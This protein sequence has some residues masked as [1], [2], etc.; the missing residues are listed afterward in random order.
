MLRFA[1]LLS[2]CCAAFALR[3]QVQTMTFSSGA[4]HP[5]FTFTNWNTDNYTIWNAD[6]SQDAIIAY[7]SGTFTLISFEVG[8]FNG[9]NTIQLTS[10]NGDTLEYN[11]SIDSVYTLNW[12]GITEIRHRRVFGAGASEDIDNV[13]VD[14]STPACNDPIP[15]TGIIGDTTVCA[16][17]SVTLQHTGG[18][19]N[20]ADYWAWYSGSCGGFV[21]DTGLSTTF[22]PSQTT[23]FY[24]GGAGG[25][26]DTLT[27]FEITVNVAPQPLVPQNATASA[28]TVCAGDSVFFTLN[29]QL[30]GASHWQWYADACNATVLG[31]G[32]TLWLTPDSSMSIFVGPSGC[33][34]AQPCAATGI[35]VEQAPSGPAINL[36]FNDTLVST[37]DAASYQWYLDGMAIQGATAQWHI[38]AASGSYTVEAFGQSGCPSPQS[39]VFI[40]TLSDTGTAVVHRDVQQ[41]HIWP[42]PSHGS[43]FIS[44]VD[45][46]QFRVLLFDLAGRQVAHETVRNGNIA[47]EVPAGAYLLVPQ[48]DFFPAVRVMME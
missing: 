35:G 3:A 17:D 31:T 10:D 22:V 28:D 30:G 48:V 44:G 9:A 38:P 19:L 27:C 33:A 1:L 43:L 18:Q 40:Y 46:P 24:L 20:D 12:A 41:V 7:N 32:D 45:R 13:V 16:G 25:C 21:S 39:A 26:I 2:V 29:G 4:N 5:G 23:T 6:L 8:P 14:I 15:P 11:A 34:S 36:T 42:N 37:V 47:F